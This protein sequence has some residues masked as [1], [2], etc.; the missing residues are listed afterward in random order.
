MWLRCNNNVLLNSAFVKTLKPYS[1]G[2]GQWVVTAVYDGGQDFL[3]TVYA[4]EAEAIEAA[5]SL[6]SNVK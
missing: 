1:Y 2:T 4:T 3:T 6:V 5:E